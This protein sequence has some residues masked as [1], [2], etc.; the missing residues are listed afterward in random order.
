MDFARTATLGRQ[1]MNA[2]PGSILESLRAYGFDATEEKALELVA[3]GAG[4]AEPF[5]GFLGARAVDSFDASLFEGA[6]H[7][8]DFNYPLGDPGLQAKYSVVLDGG[9]LEHVFNYPQAIKNCME[10][11][12]LGGDFVGIT[13]TNGLSGHGFYQI[14]PELLYQA[15]SDA[16]GFSILL[17]MSC[18]PSA[19]DWSY[20]PKPAGVPNGRVLV[21]SLGETYIFFV[22]RRTKIVPIFGTWPQQ[23]DYAAGWKRSQD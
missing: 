21:P 20:I 22:A 3:G 23:S 14:S 16:N 11:T 17:M 8:H 19:M 5:L 18:Q 4:F 1:A 9:T 15:L 2:S 10:M 6:T 7:I 13:P 12:A